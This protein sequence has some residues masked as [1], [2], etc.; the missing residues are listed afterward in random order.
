VSKHTGTTEKHCNSSFTIS[1]NHIHT[2]HTSQAQPVGTTKAAI[3]T[4]LCRKA[5]HS[6]SSLMTHTSAQRRGIGIPMPSSC[7]KW[8][9]DP[10]PH[11]THITGQKLG[12]I[13]C[14]L[15]VAATIR[16]IAGASNVSFVYSE[17]LYR[18][19]YN[20]PGRS[21]RC[22]KPLVP[23]F[24]HAFKAR[25]MQTHGLPLVGVLPCANMPSGSPH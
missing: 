3:R 25:S 18:E 13:R 23:C 15:P 5:S 11:H 14:P 6:V 2:K 7:H 22:S 19:S 16:L 17:S 4:W 21:P 8:A 9:G 1:H 12:L 10:H 20:C 24:C